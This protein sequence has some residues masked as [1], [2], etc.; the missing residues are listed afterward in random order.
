[1]NDMEDTIKVQ[2]KKK[3]NEM[4]REVE[5]KAKEKYCLVCKKR[6]SSFCNSHT[7]P[8]FILK[9]IEE[10]GYVCQSSGLIIGDDNPIMDT[11]KGIKNTGIFRCICNECDKKYFAN[12]ENPYNILKKPMQMILQEIAL[13]NTLKQIAKKKIEKQI[14]A[15]TKNQFGIQAPIA[16]YCEVDTK[17]HEKELIRILKGINKKKDVSYDLIY[18]NVLNYMSPLAYQGK[19]VL[20]VDLEGHIINNTLNEDARYFLETI[21]IA[22]FP[23]SGKTVILMF[24]DKSYLKYRSFIKQFLKL[25]E[26]E[27][28]EIINYIIFRYDEEYYI[29][30]SVYNKIKDNED[31]KQVCSNLDI[32]IR[33]PGEVGEFTKDMLNE[34]KNRKNIPNLLDD[35][36][37]I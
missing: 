32:L 30:R 37:A 3:F 14:H 6:C 2:Y 26:K 34:L 23:I 1:M 11:T 19:V 13:K 25:D 18:W 20:R 22:I 10:K 35:S 12:Y 24:I 36:F 7:V 15:Y 16:E 27:K 31:L 8:Q 17:E 28:L 9:S 29:N 5:S 4:K 33:R 21:N